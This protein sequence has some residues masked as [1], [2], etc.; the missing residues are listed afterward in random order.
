[1]FLLLYETQQVQ[2]AERLQPPQRRFTPPQSPQGIEGLA[3]RKAS[4]NQDAI[5]GMR[6]RAANP[7]WWKPS[8][9]NWINAEQQKQEAKQLHGKPNL[10]QKAL[11]PVK[12]VAHAVQKLGKKLGKLI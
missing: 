9:I 10:M 4:E 7:N 3:E 11:A 6:E 2:S 5:R 8:A 1:M 12:Q